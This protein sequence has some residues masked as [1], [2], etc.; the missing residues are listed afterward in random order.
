[1]S[2]FAFIAC[3]GAV[4]LLVMYSVSA[5]AE[6]AP[7]GGPGPST[8]PA[9]KVLTYKSTPQG[10]LTIEA[11]WPAEWKATDRRPP[12]VFFFGSGWRKGTIKQFHPQCRYFARR[13]LVA[14][15]A[16]Y[17][18][19]VTHGTTPDKAVEDARSAM[20]WIKIHAAELGIDPQKVIAG[21]G[22]AGA[23]IAL[24]AALCKEFD[25]PTDDRSVSCR[26]AA[27]L[28]YNPVLDT[29][30]PRV[31]QMLPVADEQA[32]RKLADRISPL[33]LLEKG[34]PPMVLF[35]GTDDA[36][37]EPAAAFVRKCG[38]LGIRAECY[39][40]AGQRH[41][42]FNI[43]PWLTATM[44]QTDLFLAWLGYLA[45][46]PALAAP[47]DAILQKVDAP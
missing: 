27:L 9:D 47:A 33:H 14:L 42:F 8:R 24:C 17:R 39:L 13:G 28:L 25:A 40:A 15:A 36:L 23:H 22:S 31:V 41:G 2:L 30:A 12:V 43:E 5:G 10:D 6:P 21:G 38:Q 20:R 11:F 18:V 34:A 1:M 29:T 26:P 32:R 46:E 3:L 44:R 37:A 35:Y 45:G 19:Q 4:C 7:G 16:D